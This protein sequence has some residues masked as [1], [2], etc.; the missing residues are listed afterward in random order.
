MA[1]LT[2]LIAR[3]FGAGSSTYTPTANTAHVLAILQGGGAG[4]VT[5]A[6]TDESGG[7]GG[8][9]GRSVELLDAATIGASKPYVVG[10]AAATDVGGNPTTLDT[11]GAIANAPGGSPGAATG[12]STTVGVSSAGGAGGLGPKGSL[13]VQGEPGW[14]AI[15][16]SGADGAGGAGGG[17]SGGAP[18]GSNAVGGDAG[19][20]GGGGAG[21]AA[22]G[23]P[24]RAGGGGSAGVMFLLEFITSSAQTL[25]AA[26]LVLAMVAPAATV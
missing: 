3:V 18:G 21:G 10:A 25:T 20:Y 5:A 19:A 22:G 4:G 1:N 6:A 2:G 13:N 23:A 17:P 12:G 14:R 9:G 26:A 8:E 11:A 24:N 15:Q 16:F 7:G